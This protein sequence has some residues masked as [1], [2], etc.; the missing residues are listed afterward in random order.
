MEKIKSIS[1]AP[2]T[3]CHNWAPFKLFVKLL[4]QSSAFIMKKWW[5]SWQIGKLQVYYNFLLASSKL[6]KAGDSKLWRIFNKNHIRISFVLHELFCNV[7][8]D[9]HLTI[10]ISKE[11]EI[12]G[13]RNF[14]VHMENVHK[15]F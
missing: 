8:L 12:I 4:N 13:K 9:L 1:K 3:I 15:G 6:R 2:Y 10:E 11:K 5:I 14:K 7:S